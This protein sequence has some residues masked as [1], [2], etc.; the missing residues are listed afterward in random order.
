[1]EIKNQMSKIIDSDRKKITNFVDLIQRIR[2]RPFM[3]EFKKN[4]LFDIYIRSTKHP[5]SPKT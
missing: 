2:A 5:K 3:A 4:N 1:M